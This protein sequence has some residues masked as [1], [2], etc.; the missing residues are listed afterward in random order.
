MSPDERR[1]H[2][3]DIKQY[4]AIFALEG[5]EKTDMLRQ[6]EN[7]VMDGLGTYE[8]ASAEITAW[9]LKHKTMDGFVYSKAAATTPAPTKA[10]L[11]SA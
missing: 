1:Q 2:L 6:I 4:D 5:F 9:V 3:D 7:A 10:S 11:A 8:D